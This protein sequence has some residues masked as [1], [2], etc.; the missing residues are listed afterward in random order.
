MPRDLPGFYW[1]EERKRYFP[2][3]SRPA[4]HT[5]AGPSNPVPHG[6]SRTASALAAV[7][8]QTLW[9]AKPDAPS[10]PPRKRRRVDVL[11][12]DGSVSR[13]LMG[14]GLR[15]STSH[16]QI[17]A[18]AN[19]GAM[20]EGK[21]FWHGDCIFSSMDVAVEADGSLVASTGDKGGWLQTY[22]TDKPGYP[23]GGS[24]ELYLGSEVTAVCRS[25]THRLAVSFG[26]SSKIAVENIV[27][28]AEIWN[29][30][31]IG[32]H[33]CHDVQTAHLFGKSLVLGSARRGILLSDIQAGWSFDV[34]QTGSDVLSVYQSE[35]VIYTG[36]R[37]GSIQCFDKRLNSRQKGQELFNGKFRDDN[38]SV[39]HLSVVYGTQLLASTIKGDLELLDLRFARHSTPLVEYYGHTNSY[40]PRLGIATSPCASYVFAAGQDNRIRA[41]SLQSGEPVTPPAHPP[42]PSD[43][44]HSQLL[45]HTFGDL[46][47]AICVTEGGGGGGAGGNGLSLWAASGRQIY[48]YWLGQRL[49]EGV[50]GY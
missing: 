30:I 39:T 36:A 13:G 49:G 15:L 8:A 18:Y 25:E 7:A 26:P 33:R 5:Q 31:S 3:S 22:T 38:R 21:P 47:T 2:L 44:E 17:R 29:I 20:S 42:A 16:A 43:L 14:E 1:D 4:A 50:K 10:P 23:Y 19:L 9:N 41:W 12:P 45:R 40:H 28:D 35:H 37:N 48:R 24:R 32:D 46:V 11:L 34:L 6:S 27:E